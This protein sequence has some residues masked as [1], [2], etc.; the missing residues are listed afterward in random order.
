MEAKIE[1]IVLLSVETL[2]FPTTRLYLWL[3]LEDKNLLYIV[4]S[5]QLSSYKRKLFTASEDMPQLL[6]TTHK[7]KY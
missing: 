2:C 5:A 4:Y 7:E 1:I 3:G 6:I